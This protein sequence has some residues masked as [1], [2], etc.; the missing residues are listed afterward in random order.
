MAECF[1]VVVDTGCDSV[2]RSDHRDDRHTALDCGSLLE[3]TEVDT[4]NELV[5]CTN[6]I[7]V[8]TMF[9]STTVVVMV[10]EVMVMLDS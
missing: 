8:D 10:I 4:L 5:D 9:V 3:A 2:C 7:V 6:Y 1:V